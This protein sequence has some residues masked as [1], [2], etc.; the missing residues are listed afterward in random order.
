M[1]PFISSAIPGFFIVFYFWPTNLPSWST[2]LVN[3]Y[4]HFKTHVECCLSMDIDFPEEVSCFI[5]CTSMAV[6]QHSSSH[7]STRNTLNMFKDPQWMPEIINN[8]KPY[9]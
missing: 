3:A 5:L 6:Y 2:F 7:L 9:I 4:S 1:H 8:T